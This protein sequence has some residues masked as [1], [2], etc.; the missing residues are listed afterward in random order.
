MT[1]T[2]SEGFKNARTV[3]T[4]FSYYF[5][6]MTYTSDLLYQI[7][8]STSSISATPSL[9]QAA[10]TSISVSFEDSV[11]ALEGYADIS[12]ILGSTVLSTDYIEMTFSSEFLLSTSSSVT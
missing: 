5:V 11:T 8:Q 2:I 7:D 9:A 4:S 10:I 12:A 3:K 1:I 6:Y